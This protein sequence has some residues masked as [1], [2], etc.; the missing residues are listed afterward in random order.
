MFDS[1]SVDVQDE[2]Q[3]LQHTLSRNVLVSILSNIL[4]LA[5]RLFIPPFILGYIPLAEYGLWSY[6]FVLISYFGMSVFGVT[7]VYVRYVAIYF[8]NSDY[9]S[10]NQL[11]STGLVAVTV[12]CALLLVPLWFILPYVIGLFTISQELYSKAFILF[13]STVVVFMID[14]TLGAFGYILQSLQKIVAERLIWTFSIIVETACIVIF[15]LMGFGV[16][17]LLMAFFLRNLI[18]IGLFAIMAYRY[19]PTLSLSLKFFDLSKLALFYRFGGVVQLSGV[20]G[21]VNRSI[22]KVFAGLF[23]SMEATGLY[24]VG[25][26]FPITAMLIPSSATAVFLPT[27]AHLHAQ[28]K[29]NEIRQ[30]FISGSRFVTLITGIMMGF[31]FAFAAP[32]IACWL[33]PDPKYA[34]AATILTCFTVAYQMDVM[35]GPASAIYRSI[36]KPKKELLYG[37]LQ[38]VL[39]LAAA[40]VGFSI[41][42]FTVIVI[43]SAVVSMMMLSS[44]VY[45]SY[46]CVYLKVAQNLFWKQILLPGF[47]P[48]LL[49]IIFR[50]LMDAWLLDAG[51]SRWHLLFV[52]LIALSL[53]TL[54]SVLLIYRFVCSYEERA[55]LQQYLKR[56]F[57]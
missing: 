10:I 54:T 44:M 14:L 25:V 7:N 32:L 24:E 45:M 52:L 20:L 35:T 28:K 47:L 46:S 26:K 1:Q 48:Y 56:C 42:G 8:A 39:V 27:T 43:N 53:Y 21:V 16:Y 38:F 57:C 37:A 36:G 34:V 13:F 31:L 5:T 3:E 11:I 55:K 2:S 40:G 6:C 23:I 49:G 30:I 33:G 12:L 22:E 15:L 51:S 4:Y 29:T 17:G 18:A 9:R 50:W 19:L 41:Y